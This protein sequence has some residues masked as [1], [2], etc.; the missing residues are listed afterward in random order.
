MMMKWLFT[1]K[2]AD[3]NRQKVAHK[4]SLIH[5]VCSYLSIA[6]ACWL[7]LLLALVLTHRSIS[8]YSLQQVTAVSSSG[9][10]VGKEKGL[11]ILF[12]SAFYFAQFGWVTVLATGHGYICSSKKSRTVY[13]NCEINVSLE[14]HLLVIFGLNE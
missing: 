7:I 14:S 6:V 13:E 2:Y 9:Y 3:T 1:Q 11:S 5:L 4:L 8:M 10:L 12:C